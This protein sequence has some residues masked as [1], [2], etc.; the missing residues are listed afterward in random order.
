MA[1]AVL[2]LAFA[3]FGGGGVGVCRGAVLDAV[4]GRLLLLLLQWSGVGVVAM[5]RG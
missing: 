1:L 2:A 4:A 5:I 3:V